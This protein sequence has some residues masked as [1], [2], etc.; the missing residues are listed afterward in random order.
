MVGFAFAATIV[1][2]LIFGSRKGRV[3]FSSLLA[4]PGAV[5][6]PPQPRLHPLRPGPPIKQHE[7]KLSRWFCAIYWRFFPAVPQLSG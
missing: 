7:T 6:R 5:R 1:Q 3:I 2:N 4:R